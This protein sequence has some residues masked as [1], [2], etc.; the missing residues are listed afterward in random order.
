VYPVQERTSK[1]LQSATEWTFY[2]E[3]NHHATSI[4]PHVGG[5]FGA[6]RS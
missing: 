3:I 1:A 4:L 6:N 2:W 5:L